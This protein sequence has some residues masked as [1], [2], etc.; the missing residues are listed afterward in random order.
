[1]LTY[2]GSR[3]SQDMTVVDQEL[4]FALIDLISAAVQ[5]VV[6]AI[7]MCLVT[8]YFALTLPAVIF[9]IYGKHFFPK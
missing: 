8:G 2:L 1:M 5:T 9:I 3:F 7:L 4:P 6:G